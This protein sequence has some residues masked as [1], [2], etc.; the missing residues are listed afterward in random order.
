VA[1]PGRSTFPRPTNHSSRTRP[2]QAARIRVAVL[3]WSAAEP[4][5]LPV[6]G[7]AT[8]SGAMMGAR[9][10]GAL[11]TVRKDSLA[12][13]SS[14][15]GTLCSQSGSGLTSAM[16]RPRSSGTKALLPASA[17]SQAIGSSSPSSGVLSVRAAASHGHSTARPPSRTSWHCA[18]H[19]TVIL[20]K[21]E[22]NTHA[23]TGRRKEHL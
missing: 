3:G 22:P 21:R 9:L 7:R 13:H 10:V 2:R 19:I 4:P 1:R 18:A 8:V 12:G 6:G 17:P 15:L 14:T 23:R 20:D 16:T 11:L 5:L